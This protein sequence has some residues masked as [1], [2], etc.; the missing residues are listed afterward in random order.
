MFGMMALIVMVSINTSYDVDIYRMI[1]E[2]TTNCEEEV[3]FY[4]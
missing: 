3:Q 4:K 2:K 1:I